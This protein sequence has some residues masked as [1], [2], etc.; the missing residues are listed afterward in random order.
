MVHVLLCCIV[1]VEFI[2][3]VERAVRRFRVICMKYIHYL[4]RS[5]GFETENRSFV[6]DIS[7]QERYLIEFP[8][9]EEGDWMLGKECSIDTG[10][11][12]EN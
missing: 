4:C 11:V 2:D 6:F 1:W 3:L 9:P 7:N 8:L 10:C 12:G 5:A